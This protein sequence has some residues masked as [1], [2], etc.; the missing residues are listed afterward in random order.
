MSWFTA[1]LF[2]YFSLYSLWLF[3]SLVSLSRCCVNANLF[4]SVS[5]WTEKCFSLYPN[6]ILFCWL[7]ARCISHIFTFIAA[8]ISVF[9]K[10]KFFVDL[11]WYPPILRLVRAWFTKLCR[12]SLHCSAKTHPIQKKGAN[13]QRTWAR[14]VYMNINRKLFLPVTFCLIFLLSFQFIQYHH[15]QDTV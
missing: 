11:L 14:I 7:S 13:K 15:T 9:T 10:R 1:K 3:V 2:K 8:K 6:M 4:E 12:M 5:K